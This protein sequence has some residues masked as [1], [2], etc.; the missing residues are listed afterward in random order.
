M[1]I[2]PAV[3]APKVGDP[4]TAKWAADLA[5]AVNS[6]ANP[7]DSVG[8]VSSPFGKAAL[9]PGMPMLGVARM[10]Q[11]FDCAIFRAEGENSDS[12][13]IWLP[14]IGA[15]YVIY[16]GKPLGPKAGQSIGDNSTA[17]VELGAVTNDEAHYVY[18]LPHATAGVVD[19]WEIVDSAS[20]WDADSG[21]PGDELPHVLVAF[22]DI[23]SDQRVPSAGTDNKFPSGKHGLVQCRHGTVNLGGDDPA[24]DCEVEP[25]EGVYVPGE[26]VDRWVDPRTPPGNP[27]EAIELRKF[28]DSTDVEPTQ[29]IGETGDATEPD[30]LQILFRKIPTGEDDARTKLVYASAQNG[31]FWVKGATSAQNW[32]PSIGIGTPT[33]GMVTISIYTPPAP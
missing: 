8:A 29:G 4:I 12:L 18:V 20:A 27:P 28:W 1:V 13:Y 5:A 24:T 32:A 14:G 10:P 16:N 26:S 22:Y 15:D 31:P 17:W 9:A 23:D 33:G 7:A 3:P 11:P 2:S 25:D 6:C 21:T 30:A 19:G